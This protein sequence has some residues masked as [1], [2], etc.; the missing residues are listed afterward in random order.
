[1]FSSRVPSDLAPNR[2]THAVLRVRAVGTPLLD[3]TATNPTAVGIPY[4]S[5]LLAPLADP[6][7]LRYEPS[8]LGLDSARSAGAREYSRHG[9][10]VAP[11]AIVLTASTSEAYSVLFKLL[12]G[13]EGRAAV[14]IVDEVF[15]DYLLLERKPSR[16]HR[17]VCLTFRLGGL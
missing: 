17:S 12:C 6:A 14:L 8:P 5:S 10:N 9:I 11:E 2:L 1:M 4:P 13:P 15:A 3:L 16:H 7:A